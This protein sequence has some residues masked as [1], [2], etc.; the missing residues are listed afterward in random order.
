MQV[1]TTIGDMR[2]LRKVIDG[3]VGFVPTMGYLHEGHLSLVR[4]ARQQCETVVVSIYVNPGQFAPNEDLTSYPRD[5]GR[6][7]E[8][9][10]QENVDIVFTP[11]DKQMYPDDFCTWVVPGRIAEPL[12]GASRPQF[13][14]GVD[15]IV[16]KL[17]NIVQPQPRI[18]L[19]SF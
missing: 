5:M 14:R 13:F 3:S 8:L 7:L 19:C 12:E 16:L 15:T 10:A 6:D 11:D 17:F 4:M 2:R 9:L 1:A 18:C